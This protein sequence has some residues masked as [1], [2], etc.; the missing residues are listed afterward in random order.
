MKVLDS[1]ARARDHVGTPEDTRMTSERTL[2]A[3]AETYARCATYRDSGRVLTRFL[4]PDGTLDRVAERPFRTAFVRPDR[5][6][7][8]FRDRLNDASRWFRFIAWAQGEDVGMWWDARP[9]VRRPGS[10]GLALA[11]ASAVSGGSS[12]A[13]PALLLPGRGIGPRLADLADVVSLGDGEVGGAGCHRLQGSFPLPQEGR[14]E[15]SPMTLWVDRGTL[16]IRRIELSAQAEGTRTEVV[17]DYHPEAGV[18]IGDDELAF[19]A[20][21]GD[22]T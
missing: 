2:A 19:A 15:A 9:G 4:H 13:V 17:M 20:P 22:T 3:M 18:A 16:L 10:L 21:T 11:A 12:H 5:F 1:S 14:Q 6:R 7:F 8:E